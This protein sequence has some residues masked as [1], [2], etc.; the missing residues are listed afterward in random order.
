MAK[1]CILG[2]DPG[3]T[4]AYAAISLDGSIIAIESKKN[5][6]V[7][8]IISRSVAQ[9]LKPVMIATDKAVIPSIVKKL[10]AVFNAFIYNPPQDLLVH[11][12]KKLLRNMSNKCSNIHEED[13]LSAAI[14]AYKANRNRIEKIE[15]ILGE[16]ARKLE[17]YKKQEVEEALSIARLLMLRK[18]INRAQLEERILGLLE[19]KETREEVIGIKE[20]RSIESIKAELLEELSIS[21]EKEKEK[22]KELLRKLRGMKSIARNINRDEKIKELLEELKSERKIKAEINKEMRELKNRTMEMEK[23]FNMVIGMIHKGKAFIVGK[24]VDNNPLVFIQ[25]FSRISPRMMEALE[26]NK[27]VIIS[28]TNA[29]RW[30][31]NNYYWLMIGEQDIVFESK[32]FIILKNSVKKRIDEIMDKKDI[33]SRILEEYRRE[34]LNK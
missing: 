14:Y 13:A 20:Y 5:A 19:K 15:E 25:D 28:K 1:P 27:P 24:E 6:G 4:T 31:K 23:E 17:G 26:K 22:N 2:V 10:G 9:L 21:L 30:V 16:I 8:W 33:V 11:E 12:K 3:T 29:P 18:G 34:R 32:D 7:S